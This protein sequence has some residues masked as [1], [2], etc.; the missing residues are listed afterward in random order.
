MASPV[1]FEECRDDIT[2]VK[3]LLQQKATGEQ[4][5]FPL[6]EPARVIA[7]RRECTAY[8]TQTARLAIAGKELCVAVVYVDKHALGTGTWA[9]GEVGKG[10]ERP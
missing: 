7:S 4:V 5:V 3:N 8:Y 9:V 1:R 10:A 2:I 6:I